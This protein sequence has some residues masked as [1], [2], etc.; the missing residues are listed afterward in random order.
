M[1]S[2]LDQGKEKEPSW[3]KYEMGAVESS[4]P[5]QDGPGAVF[6]P[7]QLEGYTEEAFTPFQ[8]YGDSRGNGSGENPESTQKA[9][10]IEEQEGYEKGFAQGEKDGYELGEQKGQKV[11]ENIEGLLDEMGRLRK[12]IV[13]QGEREILD[14]IFAIAEKITHVQIGLNDKTVRDTILSAIDYVNEK[15]TV[16]LRINPEDFNFVEQL[17]PEI[18][19]QFRTLKSIM[20]HADA[21]IERGGCFLETPGGDIDARIE[22]QLEKITQSMGSA[23]Q[24]NGNT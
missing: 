13:R 2:P 18:F 19:E 10:A 17:R 8:G 23:F 16:T 15:S 3:E 7:L 12:D 5:W 6:I 14:I 1:S 24:A 21:A 9:L 22:T 4:S 11:L 20:V